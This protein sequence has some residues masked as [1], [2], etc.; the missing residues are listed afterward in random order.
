V[1]DQAL[2]TA[3]R[4]TDGVDRAVTTV[5]LVATLRSEPAAVVEARQPSLSPLMAPVALRVARLV[6]DQP[7][8]TA[9]L[10]MD[11][12]DLLPATADRD[13]IVHLVPVIRSCRT[14][15]ALTPDARSRH[16][17]L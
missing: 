8:E 11:G 10:C 7:S 12:A 15:Q 3:A 5:V 16:A 6:L 9:A 13:A 1:L 17:A 4:N 14:V 2:E